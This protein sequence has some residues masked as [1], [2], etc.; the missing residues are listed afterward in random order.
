RSLERFGHVSLHDGFVGTRFRGDTSFPPVIRARFDALSAA[1]I[2]VSVVGDTVNPGSD[3]RPAGERG[4]RLLRA[5]EG[6]LREVR[7]IRIIAG[8]PAQKGIDLFIE[9]L[10]E[11]NGRRRSIASG[12]RPQLIC[13]QIHLVLT[14]LVERDQAGGQK[15]FGR[16]KIE[17]AAGRPYAP[18]TRGG[19]PER[20]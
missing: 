8:E 6:A 11:L 18:G 14:C 7:G 10:D 15:Y 12:E 3:G 13:I 2:D 1:P 4:Q 5:S 17:C 9:K 16:W 20:P 19:F